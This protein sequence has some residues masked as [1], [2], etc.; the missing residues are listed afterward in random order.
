MVVERVPDPSTPAK[1]KAVSSVDNVV[2]P[3]KGY[4]VLIPDS[5]LKKMCARF[6]ERSVAILEQ[7]DNSKRNHKHVF[8]NMLG[9]CLDGEVTAENY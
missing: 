3:E 1:E 6:L 2:T 5:A 4:E 7:P 8:G 9:S